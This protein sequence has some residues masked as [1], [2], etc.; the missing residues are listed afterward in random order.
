MQTAQSSIL[1]TRCSGILL[2]PT[3][4]PGNFGIGDLGSEAYRFI[5]FLAASGQQLWQILPLGPTGFGNSPYMSYSAMAGN[6][7]LIS[8][9][10]LKEDGFLND[11]DFESWPDVVGDR[12]DYGYVVQTKLSLFRKA[13]DRFHQRATPDQ[14]AQFQHFCQSKAYWLD[15]YAL[16]MAIKGK[17][18]GASWHTWETDLAK[19]EPD[20]LE[21]CKRSL[22]NDIFFEKFLQFEFFRQWSGIKRYANSKGI[23]IM[24]DIPIYVAQDSADVWA[25]R[26][27]FWLDEETNEPVVMAGAPPDFFSDTG[28]VWGNPVYKWE[29]LQQTGF[30]WWIQRFHAMLD[31]VDLIRIDHFVGFK[32]FW[33]VPQGATDARHG[34]WVEAPGDAFFEALK[35]E[36]GALPIFAEDLG[37]ITPEVEALRN[38]FKF[39]GMKI[40]HFAFSEDDTHPYLPFNYDRNFLV[41]TGTHDN[42]TTVGW[43]EQLKDKE[44]DNVLTYLGCVS[45][46]GIHWDMIRLAFS[47]IANFAVIPL[48]DILGLGTEARMNVPGRQAG[49]WEWRYQANALTSECCDRLKHLTQFFGRAPQNRRESS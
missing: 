28:Q 10:R 31:Y 48:Q 39:P 49:N 1:L 36:L 33:A 14:T 12:V 21:Q 20:T 8:P 13:S 37:T 42:D 35:Q 32:L 23:Q 43:Y 18:K 5:D 34:E 24:G 2:H 19:R 30:R 22:A 41:Y 46:E 11:Q 9:D 40:L 6:P 7:L 29:H 27:N 16:F 47:S 45:S 26:Q 44:R 38:R 15:D 17:K 4:F 3:S 25:H